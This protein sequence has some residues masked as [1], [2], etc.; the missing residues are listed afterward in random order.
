MG[1]QFLVWTV[2]FSMAAW[3][4]PSGTGHQHTVS[5]E[6]ES[7]PTM[8]SNGGG[9]PPSLNL[10]NVPAL[11]PPPPPAPPKLSEA[12]KVQGTGAGVRS[13]AKALGTPGAR[14]TSGIYEGAAASEP[15]TPRTPAP[16][17]EMPNN[18]PENF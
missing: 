5:M 13:R 18:S 17:P 9:P 6:G 2:F 14:D 11:L 15:R 12:T 7:S 16:A 8:T 3:A 4:D 1:T 10:G